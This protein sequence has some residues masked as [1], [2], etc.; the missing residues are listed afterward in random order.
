M[1][2]DQEKK[3]IDLETISRLIATHILWTAW[4]VAET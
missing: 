3:N 2:F 1:L 4:E